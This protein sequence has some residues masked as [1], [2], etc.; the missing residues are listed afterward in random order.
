M[1]EVS[2]L[3]VQMQKGT[4]PRSVENLPDDRVKKYSV[5]DALVQEFGKNSLLITCI[6][7]PILKDREGDLYTQYQ[8][9]AVDIEHDD[10]VNLRERAISEENTAHVNLIMRQKLHRAE[11]K[12]L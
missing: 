4:T 7:S 8:Y 12:K 6:H 10:Y 11:E 2:F 9:V 1:P 3:G 5:P